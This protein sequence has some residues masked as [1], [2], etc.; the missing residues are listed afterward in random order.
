MNRWDVL[1][2]AGTLAS[3]FVPVFIAVFSADLT[4]KQV[5]TA[6]ERRI[7]EYRKSLYSRL[8]ILND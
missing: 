4:R 7:A 8:L 3:I 2:L 1:F 6:R 5:R